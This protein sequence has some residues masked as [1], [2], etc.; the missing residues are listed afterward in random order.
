MD[1]DDRYFN[2][3]GLIEYTGLSRQTLYRYMNDPENPLP[4]HHIHPTGKGRGSVL[5]RKREFDAWV[6]RFPGL[7]STPAK[8]EPRMALRV[9]AAVKSIRGG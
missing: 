1:D 8:V 9:A 6:A 5:I 2:I 4:H 3:R 7:K